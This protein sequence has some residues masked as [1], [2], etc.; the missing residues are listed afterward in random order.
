MSIIWCL[1]IACTS[2]P[3]TITRVTHTTPRHLSETS[4]T[5]SRHPS[6]TARQLGEREPA[7]QNYSNWIVINWF[8]IIPPPPP[9]FTVPG[10]KL[11]TSKKHL[12]RFDWVANSLIGFYWHTEYWGNW[13]VSGWCLEG[14]W[15]VSECSWIYCQDCIDGI[16]TA[17]TTNFNN[18]SLHNANI[19]R[20]GCIRKVSGGCLGDSGY[21][22]EGYHAKSIDETPMKEHWAFFWLAGS[23]SFNDSGTTGLAIECPILGCLQSV[24]EVSG[25]CLSDSGYCLCLGGVGGRGGLL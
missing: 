3:Q 14:F 7:D 2:T 4:Q 8:H 10:H 9:S 20:F 6:Y 25:G 19:N 1:W 15:V 24:W 17:T 12:N 23:F 16:T 22:L 13:I 21:C 18:K 5:P 11:E